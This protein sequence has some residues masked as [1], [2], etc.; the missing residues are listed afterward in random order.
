M[1]DNL[2]SKKLLLLNQEVAS[3]RIGKDIIYSQANG[4]RYEN[5]D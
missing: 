2:H 1:A 5:L 4:N 3:E